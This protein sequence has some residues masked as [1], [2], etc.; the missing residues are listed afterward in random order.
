MPASSNI[1]FRTD[2]NQS[3]HRPHRNRNHEQHQQ[4]D[5]FA[6]QNRHG[7]F[8]PHNPRDNANHRFP[9]SSFPETHYTQQL[10]DVRADPISR[11]ILKNDL[12]R[13]LGE[14]YDGS[15]QRFWAWYYDINSQLLECEAS[16]AE[17]VLIL[18]ANTMKYSREIIDNLLSGG[19]YNPSQILS[20]IW[21]TF[22]NRFGSNVRVTSHLMDRLTSFPE[23][24][25]PNQ[26]KDM[27]HLLIICKVIKLN[28]S[29]SSDLQYFETQQGIREVW[30]KLPDIFVSKWR[31]EV[32]TS[33][34]ITGHTP[35]F[36][37]FIEFFSNLIEE[38]ANPIFLPTSN[39]IKAYATDVQIPSRTSTPN[40][41]K[42]TCSYHNMP[43]HSIDTC[44]NFKNLSYQE[45][46]QF[47]SDRKL[48]FNCLGEHRANDCRSNATCSMC[49]RRHIDVMHA[50]I[51]PLSNRRKLSNN[52]NYRTTQNPDRPPQSSFTDQENP[53][54]PRNRENQV[55]PHFDRIHGG[56]PPNQPPDRR[57]RNFCLTVCGT[58]TM[59]QCSKTVPV[60]IRISGSNEH[61]R[62]L[63]I[64]DEQ[65]NS[66][67]IDESVLQMISVPQAQISVNDYKLTTL[68]RLST[69]IHSYKI[70]CIQVKGI[71]E[72]KWIS[73]PSA[74]TH[75]S[76]PDT[77]DE[78][79]SPM[80][81]KSHKHISHLAHKFPQI[82][83]SLEVLL[84]VGTNC[85]PAMQTQSF[86]SKYPF[87][88]HTALG[89][90]LVG[91]SCLEISKPSSIR[92]LRSQIISCEHFKS[93]PSL[94]TPKIP[95]VSSSTD[96]FI[97]R[98]NDDL[99]GMKTE[100][101]CKSLKR[102][103]K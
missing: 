19:M 76:L 12:R 92:A 36:S 62:C 66:T 88:H 84:L 75:P 85:G 41:S 74:L 80:I 18:K 3:E 95:S 23:I 94:V 82:D 30:S 103:S 37:K 6:T 26:I 52:G 87:A 50:D 83:P 49:N 20:E 59:K 39:K 96:I 15:P 42:P 72:R 44:R 35:S 79:A 14:K 70:S 25:S 1:Q 16:P 51:H 60:D 47:A 54:S 31:K 10:S 98:E 63:C 73:L 21:T 34:R 5:D 78:T 91:P 81:V 22:K 8:H 27:E 67:F 65:S 90:A 2:L 69:S 11:R 9:S 57:P 86:G 100:T 43:G 93:T 28:M 40:V 64:I 46:R 61:L 38:Y 48:C 71:N 97:E 77:R 55:N 101:A 4:E 102:E 33:Q 32:S 45:R 56:R 89:W 68:S 13:G 58:S 29:E 53:T 99:P 7:N 17:T 24:S